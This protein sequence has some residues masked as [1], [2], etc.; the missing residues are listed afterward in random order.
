MGE[1]NK[2]LAS[3]TWQ[4][5]LP[6]EVG[7][8]GFLLEEVISKCIDRLSK[9]QE[10]PFS[11]D[12]NKRA[13]DMLVEALCWLRTRTERR[14]SAGVEGTFGLCKGDIGF[15]DVVGEVKE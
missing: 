11:C 1:Y 13:I 4:N 2:D 12:E 9:F 14:K 7:R 15:G 8:N 10:S 3:I 5:G 6:T